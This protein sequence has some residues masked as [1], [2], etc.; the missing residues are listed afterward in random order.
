MPLLFILGIIDLIAGIALALT[1]FVPLAASGLILAIGVILALKGG[2]S[3]LAAAGAGFYFDV[4]GV[5]DLLSGIF[6]ILAFYGTV[7]GFFVW[8]G[9]AMILKALWS[10]VVFMVR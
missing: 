2:I 7:L 10:I 5:L 6:L 3:Y 1:G 9:V 4:L 8:F